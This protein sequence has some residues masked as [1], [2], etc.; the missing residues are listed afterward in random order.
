MLNVTAVRLGGRRDRNRMG[1][2]RRLLRWTSGS[3][4]PEG[5]EGTDTDPG[6]AT[7]SGRGSDR[8]SPEIA[9]EVERRV[10]PEGDRS[11]DDGT[12]TF[13]EHDEDRV[14]D[15][16]DERADESRRGTEGSGSETGTSDPGDEADTS[17]P[18]TASSV[19]GTDDVSTRSPDRH[20]EA[21]DAEGV[22][23]KGDDK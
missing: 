2:V 9:S 11:T 3:K 20:L 17:R 21:G 5:N 12:S 18:D 16:E 13:E 15:P 8:N 14:T 1:T 4:A 19:R 6:G 23:Y 22:G 10:E 7:R